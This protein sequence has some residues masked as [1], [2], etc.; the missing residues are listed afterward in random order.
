M[1]VSFEANATYATGLS[2]NASVLYYSNDLRMYPL[3][4][5]TPS[6]NVVGAAGFTANSP[7]AITQEAVG[8]NRLVGTASPQL[9]KRCCCYKVKYDVRVSLRLDID[10]YLSNG[11]ST[12]I[13]FNH[14]RHP[15]HTD[16]VL[17]GAPNTTA[18]WDQSVVQPDVRVKLGTP[19][20]TVGR[21]PG[22]GVALDLAAAHSTPPVRWSGT[23]WT[24]K[25]QNKPFEAFL[26]D[27][28]NWG[29]SS[30]EPA[31][32]SI[33]QFQGQQ[34]NPN[35]EY[36]LS[37]GHFVQF[38]IRATYFCLLKDKNTVALA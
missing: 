20:M 37:V 21:V 12:P 9:Y 11:G 32:A 6:V 28:V 33:I 27:P 14:L 19:T 7:S 13:V 4:Y 30:V 22:T 29:T 15:C 31:I 18:V 3:N 25:E 1:A 34:S 35:L 10:Q 2:G 17:L 36:T 16:D 23:F 24:H 38:Q 5:G 26:E 8:F